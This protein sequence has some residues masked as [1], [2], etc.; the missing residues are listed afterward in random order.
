ML[1]W[2]DH[3]E[4][5]L[6]IPVSPYRVQKLF[7]GDGVPALKNKWVHIVLAFLCNRGMCWVKETPDFIP[8]GMHNGNTKVLRLYH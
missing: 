7:L 8:H 6:P 1:K 5:A 2:T 4:A 3:A